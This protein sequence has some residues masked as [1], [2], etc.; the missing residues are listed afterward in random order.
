[1]GNLRKKKEEGK[2]E[3]K[4]SVR[5][6]LDPQVSYLEL[7]EKEKWQLRYLVG[8]NVKKKGNFFYSSSR[9]TSGKEI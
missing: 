5:G 4:G 9:L 3:G 6:L 7:A 8:T 2:G 1:M